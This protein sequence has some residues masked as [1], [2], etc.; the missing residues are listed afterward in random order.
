MS[1]DE[2]SEEMTPGT[3]RHCRKKI[4]TMQQFME[5]LENDVLPMIFERGPGVN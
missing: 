1:L 5:H 3:A 2:K 4:Q